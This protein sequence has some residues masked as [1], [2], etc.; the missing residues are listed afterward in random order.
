MRLNIGNGGTTGTLGAG[1]VIINGDGANGVLGFDR[2]NG[3]TLAA[4]QTI[5][6]AGTPKSCS[7]RAKVAAFALISC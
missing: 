3:Y 6:G 2:S 5:T 1:N 4:G 7:I